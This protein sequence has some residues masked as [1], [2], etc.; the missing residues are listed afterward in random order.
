V[1]GFAGEEPKL[2][3]WLRFNWLAKLGPDIE[4]KIPLQF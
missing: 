1:K 2:R 4:E 3:S